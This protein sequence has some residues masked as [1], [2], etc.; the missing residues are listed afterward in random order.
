MTDVE[1]ENLKKELREARRTGETKSDEELNRMEAKIRC[2]NMINSIIAYS[3]LYCNGAKGV[4]GEQ[5]VRYEEQGRHNYLADHI[6]V[7]GRETVTK[8]AEEQLADM[9][10]VTYD[11]FR[12]DD[13]LC[14][15]E[16][17]WKR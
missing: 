2:I 12:D 11:V 4:T 10:H 8:L 17:I 9:S 13:G 1:L 15:N 6:K 14:Y 16:I 7:L 5:F 3:P